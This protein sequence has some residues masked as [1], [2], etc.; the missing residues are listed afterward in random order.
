MISFKPQIFIK[1]QI[2]DNSIFLLIFFG[3]FYNRSTTHQ[4]YKNRD[5]QTF[6][7]STLLYGVHVFTKYKYIKRNNFYIIDFNFIPL[8]RIP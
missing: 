5:C 7:K 8:L 6:I 2:L 1:I 3:L 4:G